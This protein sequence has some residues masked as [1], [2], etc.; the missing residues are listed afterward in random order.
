MHY[1]HAGPEGLDHFHILMNAVIEDVNL[2][3]HKALT[4]IYAVVLYK[5]HGKD[6]K[7]ARSYRTIST[8][9]LLAKALDVYVRGLSEDDWN[10]IEAETQF[11]VSKPNYT[12]SIDL[13]FHPSI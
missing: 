6:K 12:Y 1:L 7:N 11:L 9:P 8:C 3:G 4:S 2:S 5:G 13:S 10:A